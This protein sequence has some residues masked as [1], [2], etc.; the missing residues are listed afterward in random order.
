MLLTESSCSAK[1]ILISPMKIYLTNSL[2]KKK[3]E[4]KAIKADKVTMYACG[5]T[6]YDRPHLGNARAA[7][8]Y[9]VL[10]R[11]LK[12]VYKEVIYA[13]NITDV[14]DKIIAACKSGNISFS[15]LTTKMIN[16]YHEDVA[17]LNCLSPTKE[18]KATEYIK[19][20]IGMIESLISRGFAYAV[21]GH[22][23]FSVS[24]YKDYG[25]L[26]N[27]SM[28][29]MIAGARVEVAPYKKHPADFVLWKPSP[30]GEED[31]GFDSPWAGVGQVGI[32]NV[33]P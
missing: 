13:R 4:F 24:E 28:D 6:V 1:L 17:A 18:P 10:F 32:L 19:Q 11:L 26:S 3:E 31:F 14:D 7:V 29:E 30:K 12:A 5:P 2:T 9:D 23:L 21:E 8:T 22:V 15:D 27:R 33:L 20:M 16:H 25:N